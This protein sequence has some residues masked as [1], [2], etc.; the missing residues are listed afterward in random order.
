MGAHLIDQAYWAWSSPAHSIEATSSLWALETVPVPAGAPPEA[1]PTQKTCRSHGKHGAL[2]LPG[3]R[4]ARARQ[5]HVV[6]WRVVSAAPGFY[7]DEVTFE[8]EGGG[9]LIGSKG[10][11]T[12]ETYGNNPRVYPVPVAEEAMAVPRSLPASKRAIR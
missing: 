6:R 7:P 8:S 9:V 3:Q 12:H 5:A 2:Q 4:K 1:R 11:I 10:V